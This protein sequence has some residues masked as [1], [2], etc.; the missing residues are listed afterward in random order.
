MIAMPHKLSRYG[1]T[2]LLLAIVG[3]LCQIAS[4]Y[5]VSFL[6]VNPVIFFTILAAASLCEY[7]DSSLGM[8]YGTTLTPI[9]LLSGFQPLQV[10]PAILLSE[11]VTGIFA[12]VMHHRDGNV[13][14]L[15]DR[16]A[17]N[18]AILLFSLSGVGAILAACVAISISK[19]WLNLS[20]CLIVLV[21]AIIILATRNRHIPFNKPMMVGVGALAA[22]NKS[23]SGGGYGPLVTAGQLVSGVP[24][25][26]A[27]AISSVAESVTCL[28]GLATY[29][30]L[31]KYIDWSLA[32]PLCLGAVLSV[33]M[34]THTVRAV[35]ERTMKG[36]VGVCTLLLGLLSLYKLM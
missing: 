24:A 17:R 14:F 29:L 11:L 35:E 31:G 21:M 9:L 4:S 10:V 36:L 5:S 12:G 32:V 2:F 26:S 1:V 18:T 19:F 27:V 13:N 28:V 8:G 3:T 20:I 15:E 23:L 7:M 33:P 34:A 30:L 6:G 22:F 25:K 16:A